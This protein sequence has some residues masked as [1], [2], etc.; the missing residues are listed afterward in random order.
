MARAGT[1][2]VRALGPEA[3]TDAR[4]AVILCHGFGAPGDDLVPLAGACDVGAMRWFFPEAPLTVDLGTDEPGRA[5]WPIDMLALQLELSRGAR[6]WDPAATPEGLFDARD[7]LVET[8]H[9]LVHNHGV[10]P[11]RTILG[12]FS[13]GAMLATEVALTS[14]LDFAGLAILSG[15]KI[16]ERAWADGLGSRGRTLRV[17]QSHGRRDPLLPFAVAEELHDDFARA[18]ADI[19][20]VPF[21]GA[22]EIPRRVLDSFAGFVRATL[23][24]E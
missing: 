12:G 1:L 14:G 6:A 13:Q 5:W 16:H 20:F 23:R 4:G 22:H 2:R 7:A 10:D 18:G 3:Q 24:G 8:L 19:T 9:A 11:T 21:D 15:S 17:F